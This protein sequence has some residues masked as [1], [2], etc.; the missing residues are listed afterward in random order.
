MTLWDGVVGFAYSETLSVYDGTPPYAWSLY[1][2]SL[3][4]GLELDSSGVIS[5]MAMT[6]DVADFSVEV[7]DA[8]GATDS[9]DLSILI[10]EGIRGDINCD[11]DIDV[12]DVMSCVD[13][14]LGLSEPTPYRQWSADCYE[15]DTVNVL[16][17]VCIVKLI[18]DKRAMKHYKRE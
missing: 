14:I 8:N 9:Q 4:E 10:R 18:L 7:A 3:P 5:G 1:S 6:L 2:G 12:T 17:V 11:S 13:M 15:D 16:D